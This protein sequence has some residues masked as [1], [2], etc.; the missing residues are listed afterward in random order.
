MERIEKI[1]NIILWALQGFLVFLLIFQSR[2]ELPFAGIGHLHPLI[3]HLPIGFGVLLLGLFAIK[4]QLA[5]FKILADFLLLLTA[6]FSSLTAI[7][8]LFLSK[9]G[10]YEAAA[11]DWHQ[12]SGVAVSF[13]YFSWVLLRRNLFLGSALG[14]IALVIAGHTG[15]SITHGEDYLKFGSQ[16]SEISA[17][18]VVFEDIVQPI[19]K[20]KCE[21]C[22]N[23]QKT[24]GALKMNSIAGLL[25]G[26]KHGPI[27]KAGDALNSHLIQRIKLPLN[28]KEHMPPLGKVQL[29]PDEITILTL[30]VKEG[31]SVDRKL[32]EFSKE[33]Q[34]LI[35]P[36][37]LNETTKSYDFS[38]ASESDLK[39]VNTPYCTVYPVAYDSPALS[40]DFFVA[41]KFDPKT[42]ENLSQVQDQ[43]VG[44]QLSK[45]PIQDPDLKKVAKFTNLEKLNLNFTAVGDAGLSSLVGLSHLEKLSISGTK[46]T[47]AGLSKLLSS[48]SALKEI[49]V[50]NTGITAGEMSAFRKQFP[51]IHFDE[52]YI[53]KDEKLQINPPI[54]VNENLIL[55]PGE[56][57]NFKHTLRDVLFRYT[58][59][60]SLPDS[61]SSLQTRASIDIKNF[62]NVRIIATKNG[63][64]ASNPIDVRVYKSQ[65]IPSRIDLL[66]KT[67][68]KYP[69]AGGASLMDFIP[70]AREVK[71]VSNF[72]WLGFKV[73]DFDAV[74][75]FAKPTHIQ[76][77]TFSYLEKTD[78]DVFP[79]T[80][81]EVWAGDDAAKLQLVGRFKPE[82]PK[83]KNGYSPKGINIPIKGVTAKYYRVKAARLRNL[84][85]FVDNKGKGAWLRVD[86]LLFY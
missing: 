83:E 86:E 22:H 78:S 85:A 67:D 69:A 32:G 58:V 7:F 45:M 23:D 44:L 41:G 4:K 54:L 82:Q 38:E 18:S 66:S 75:T 63:W 10:G 56:K 26:G 14:F 81:I 60:D 37:Q 34:G 68:P 71:G 35:K 57:L 73:T 29:T 30:W 65:F 40:A 19:L 52:G 76:G 62:T 77:V 74:A 12:W 51:K 5:S 33:F 15:A 79:P 13:V 25:K 39:A 24:K 6:I 70:G 84:P 80:S 8:G 46:V 36:T 28:V 20:A 53:P 61:L 3:L 31:A 55:R 42:L 47:R 2:I 9:E 16:Q 1:G 72:T 49:H 48:S 27:W 43:L 64:L 50:W 59:N 21:S 11:L 17:E